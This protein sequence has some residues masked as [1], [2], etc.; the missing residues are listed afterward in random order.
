[1]DRYCRG[2][3]CRHR[4]LVQYFGQGYDS[5]SCEACDL[6]LGET[7]ELP[8]AQVV[9]QKIL[10]C[11]ARARESFGINHIA[12]ILRGENTENIRKRGHDKLSTFGLLK[13]SGKPELRDWIYQLI[14]QGVLVQ[15]GDEYPILKLNA[16]AWEVMRGQR[17]VR[18]VQLAR[19]RKTEKV[20]S[21]VVSWEGVDRGLFEELRKLRYRL[22]QEGGV[23]P[24]VIF[25]DKTLRQLARVRPSSP[26]KMRGVSGVGETKLRK[27]GE[28]FLEVILSYSRQHELPLDNP[29][30]Q[31]VFEE[32]PRGLSR[33]NPQRTQAFEL[34]RKGVALEKVMA[35]IGRARSTVTEYLCDYIREERPASVT[36]WVPDQLYQRIAAVARQF[37]MERLKPL[38][39]ALGETVPYEDIRVVLTH[40]A[41]H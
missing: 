13:G 16:A 17:P 27:F 40:L 23:P 38:H 41:L 6:C 10:S 7:E 24:Y 25:D 34:F 14:G 3:V 5:K 12:G 4:A 39:V 9:A 35:Q 15:V 32:R 8:E 18:L 28:Q 26:E 33:P 37:G 29:A 21:E 19:G 1:M 2:A 31:V 11:V 36:P 30:G 22:A 20:R